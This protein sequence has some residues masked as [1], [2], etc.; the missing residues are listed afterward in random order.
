VGCLKGCSAHLRSHA[1]AAC[2]LRCCQLVAKAY[3]AQRHQLCTK[4]LWQCN[5]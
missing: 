2:L 5:A 3:H 1:P 4:C